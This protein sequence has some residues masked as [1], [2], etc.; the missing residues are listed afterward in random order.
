MCCCIGLFPRND[1]CI[2]AP[3]SYAGLSSSS[4]S[5]DTLSRAGRMR[6]TRRSFQI[7][8]AAAMMPAC[9]LLGPCSMHDSSSCT[10]HS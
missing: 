1:D 5:D 7:A 8:V 10:T 2:P 6:C 3:M 4:E 9:A